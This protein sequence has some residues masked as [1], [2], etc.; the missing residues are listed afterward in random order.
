[1]FNDLDG[2]RWWGIIFFSNYGLEDINSDIVGVNDDNEKSCLE[3][4]PHQKHK[5]PMGPRLCQ[6]VQHPHLPN[7][8]TGDDRVA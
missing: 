4:N 2:F 8:L 7:L 5:E 3:D 6:L 1:M